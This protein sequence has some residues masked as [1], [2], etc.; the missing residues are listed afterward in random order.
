M[1]N[2]LF[3][4]FFVFAAPSSLMAVTEELPATI[5]S[6]VLPNTLINSFA[7]DLAVNPSGQAVAIWVE[8][9]PNQGLVNQILAAFFNPV[10]STWSLPVFLGAGSTPQVAINASGNAIAVWLSPDN[11]TIIDSSLNQVVAAHFNSLTETWTFPAFPVSTILS[12][13]SRPQ[14][15][16]NTAGFGLVAWVESAPFFSSVVASGFDPTIFAW[17]APALLLNNP[18]IG[19]VVQVNN[20]VQFDRSPF[21]SGTFPEVG[22]SDTTVISDL[23]LTVYKG[24]VIWQEFTNVSQNIVAATVT[25]P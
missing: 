10:T 11:N 16:I 18:Q 7:P 19:N 2:Y 21:F 8:N 9:I 14:V 12:V 25:V 4:F 24:I 13:N 15:A 1:K 23:G 5:I 3:L 6:E 20:S 22:L 17:S